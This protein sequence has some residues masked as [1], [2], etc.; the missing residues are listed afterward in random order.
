MENWWFTAWERFT[1]C[2]FGL[3]IHRRGGTS[4]EEGNLRRFLCHGFV[5]S[6][7]SG[8]REHVN[9]D[10]DNELTGTVI[11]AAITV[12]RALG[13]GVEEAAY[14]EALSDKLSNL[15]IP[16]EQAQVFQKLP[17]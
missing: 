14:E 11:G 9:I 3:Q 1:S 15:A 10:R 8:W 6:V 13:P 12:H 4:A 16:H 7:F 2:E 5:R 17:F